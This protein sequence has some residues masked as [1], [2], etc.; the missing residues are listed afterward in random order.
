MCQQGKGL[1]LKL[2]PAA[3]EGCFGAIASPEK[4]ARLLAF[5][6]SALPVPPATSGPP[7]ESAF[8]ASYDK[9]SRDK[10]NGCGLSSGKNAQFS[11]VSRMRK[12]C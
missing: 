3:G 2:G 5:L 9:G 8:G 1:S 12:L 4:L 11:E 6:L 7:G 10:R